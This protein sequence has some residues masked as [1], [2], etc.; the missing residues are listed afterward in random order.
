MTFLGCILLTVEQS[1]ID[2]GDKTQ[3]TIY[4]D[5]NF[6]VNVGASRLG[7]GPMDICTWWLGALLR[8]L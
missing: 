5:E 2:L 1:Q 8:L 7:G 3:P 4:I 6:V